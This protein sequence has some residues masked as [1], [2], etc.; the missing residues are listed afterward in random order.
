MAKFESPWTKAQQI[1]A[2]PCH[3]G[4]GKA[5]TLREPG[6]PWAAHK[7][8]AEEG[9]EAAA[10]GKPL[11]NWDGEEH[12]LTEDRPLGCGPYPAGAISGRF[13]AMLGTQPAC[14]LCPASPSYFD[15][16]P[17]IWPGQSA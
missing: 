9:L 4:C 6:R 11:G 15:P 12:K 5:A 13:C 17:R 16:L 14:Q 2:Q 8:C 7:V 3:Y 1:K 10:A